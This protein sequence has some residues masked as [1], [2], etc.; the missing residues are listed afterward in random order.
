MAG[1][2]YTPSLG[3]GATVLP[4]PTTFQ[5]YS[6][7][8]GSTVQLAWPVDNFPANANVVAELMAVIPLGTD[9]VM[10]MPIAQYTSLGEKGL[11]F[12]GGSVPFV[13]ADALGNTII[14]IPSGAAYYLALVNNLTQQG[15][16]LSFQFGAGTSQANAADLA[17]AGLGA[18]GIFLQQIMSMVTLTQAYSVGPNDRDVFFNWTSG[19]G[20]L[21][22]P[23][24]NSVG[25]DFYI[26]AR[27]SGS[28]TLTLQPSGSDQ[29][30]ASSSIA[31]NVNDSAFIVTDG[32]NWW[33]LGLGQVN[34]NL[35]NFQVISLGG[36]TG[37]YVLPANL[38]GK[39]AY[40]FTGALAAN[41][42]IQVPASIQQYWVDNETSGGFSLSIATAAQI[43]G[44]TP[45]IITSGARFILYCDSNNVLN[46]DT[47]GISVPLQIN[48]GGTGATSA[49]AALISLG[50]TSTGIALFTAASTAAAQTA[51]SVR[52]QSDSDAWGIIF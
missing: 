16:W 30:N 2:G 29:I 47:A 4:S 9:C 1:Q 34:T 3:N 46:A 50:G 43:S 25:N 12:N 39:V 48:Q 32:V 11:F 27:N 26:Q 6:I 45:F 44:G 8:A 5:S 36:Q 28:G 38:Q 31:F 42:V 37:T 52:S 14:S 33:T 20:T 22:L 41:V 23:L 19:S 51:L 15:A 7:T 40:R 10:Q 49:G 21:T 24:A 35:F 13:V 17:G 18:N